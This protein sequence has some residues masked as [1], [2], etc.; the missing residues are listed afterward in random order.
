MNKNYKE[1]KEDMD[2]LKKFIDRKNTISKFVGIESEIFELISETIHNIILLLENKWLQDKKSE[3]IA[4]YVYE[5]DFGLK[6]LKAGYDDNIKPVKTI[7]DLYLI[8]KC[9]K[10]GG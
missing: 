7:L 9:E 6:K 4:W 3:W 8:I 2:S 5:N 1:F 10:K